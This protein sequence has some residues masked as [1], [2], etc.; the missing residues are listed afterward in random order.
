MPRL[1]SAAQYHFAGASLRILQFLALAVL[2]SGCAQNVV[3]LVYPAPKEAVTPKAGSPSVCVVLFEDRRGKAEIGERRDGGKFQPRTNVASWISRAM[4][5]ELAQTGLTVTYADDL[6]QAK[7]SN[8]AYILTGVIDEVWLTENSLTRLTC[9]M[10]VTL[11]LLRGNGSYITKNNYHSTF[12]Q[13][14]IP[15]SDAPQSILSEGL[16]DL[17]RPAARNIER[18]LK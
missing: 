18:S 17:L 13:T 10:R 5:D 12:S 6:S 7:A 15:T 8:P 14:V 4:A 2:L 3:H 16:I 11:S 1:R 9:T